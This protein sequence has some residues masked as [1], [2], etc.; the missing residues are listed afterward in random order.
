MV[1]TVRDKSRG[2]Y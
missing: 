1:A 2:T